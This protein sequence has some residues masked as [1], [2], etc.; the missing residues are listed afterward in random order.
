MKYWI[1][2]DTKNENY[3]EFSCFQ[4][5]NLKSEFSLKEL[6]L[7]SPFEQ[8]IIDAEISAYETSNCS[9]YSP[10]LLTEDD[11]VS[12]MPV[13]KREHAK[14]FIG[15][16]RRFFALY[17]IDTIGRITSFI[18]NSAEESTQWT[19]VAESF[20]YRAETLRDT[21]RHLF[22]TIEMA[23]EA[24]G[25]T[26]VRPDRERQIAIANRVY[27]GKNGNGNEA[28]GDGWKYRGRG[29]MQITGRGTYQSFTDDTGI[30]IISDPDCVETP[31]YSV[32]T[33]CWFWHKHKL[34]SCADIR[35]F[36]QLAYKINGGWP[37][38]GWESRE[39]FRKR[40]LQRLK[41]NIEKA[42]LL[43]DYRY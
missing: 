15:Y 18:G 14:Q 35:A 9:S 3:G 27:A 8:N 2:G 4:N 22:P 36:E 5:Q 6:I 43:H 13:L 10:F 34:S 33:G 24:I 21:F 7:K 29:I 28:S 11:L 19:L 41:I 39:L 32:F 30:D 37:P 17:G 40:A 25:K 42:L 16:V 26:D 38:K 1:K 20:V 12:I 23:Q 31:H